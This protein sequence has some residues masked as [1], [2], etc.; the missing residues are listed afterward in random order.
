MS[1]KNIHVTHRKDDSWAVI[2]EKDTRAS[3]LYD[4]QAEALRAGRKLAQAN[5]SE[6]VIHGRD[7]KI[8]D[9]DSFGNDPNPPKDTKH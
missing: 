9:K 2:G 7:N 8:I 1:K 6:L 5:E 3:G 4:T